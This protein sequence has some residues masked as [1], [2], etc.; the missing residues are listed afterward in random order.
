MF[1]VVGLCSSFD[2]SLGNL[3]SV[4]VVDLMLFILIFLMVRLIRVLLVVIWWL[5]NV[6]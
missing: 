5:L 1:V 3:G 6:F 4:L 2:Y